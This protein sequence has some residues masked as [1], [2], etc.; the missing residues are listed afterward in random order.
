MTKDWTTKVHIYLADRGRALCGR[1]VEDPGPMV[2]E[3]VLEV[4]CEVCAEKLRRII[5]QLNVLRGPGARRPWH[6]LEPR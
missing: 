6:E 1:E 2:A 3:N 5:G 4:T